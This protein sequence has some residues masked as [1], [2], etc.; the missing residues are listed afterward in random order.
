MAWPT[1]RQLS[2][3]IRIS[4]F[5]LNKPLISMNN[6]RYPKK[7]EKRRCY[8]G[9][10]SLDLAKTFDKVWL[11]SLL[12]QLHLIK[13]LL[14]TILIQIKSNFRNRFFLVKLGSVLFNL[15]PIKTSVPQGPYLVSILFNININSIPLP[16]KKIC[17]TFPLYQQHCPQAISHSQLIPRRKLQI[18]YYWIFEL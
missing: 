3:S 15:K 14:L 10:I 18:R 1:I 12:L 2:F 16:P 8:N 17:R 6:L 4:A 7:H 11:K 9:M 5:S 13:M